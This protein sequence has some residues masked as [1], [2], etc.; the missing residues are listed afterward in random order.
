[1]NNK[2]SSRVRARKR[3]MKSFPCKTSQDCKRWGMIREEECVLGPTREE[4]CVLG[5]KREEAVYV[6]A[7]SCPLLDLTGFSHVFFTCNDKV[8][9][10][11]HCAWRDVLLYSLRDFTNH[12]LFINLTKDAEKTE[13]STFT[14][15][16]WLSLRATWSLFQVI[17]L[18]FFHA[19][20]SFINTL[21]ILFDF[22]DQ[23]ET[24]ISIASLSWLHL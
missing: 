12:L 17:S 4:E 11:P 3:M 22:Q 10:N 24:C 13:R 5:P 18:S 23:E 1:M 16:S 6:Y 19:H 2:S 9:C 8:V 20:T 7:A 21:H 15:L 14:H